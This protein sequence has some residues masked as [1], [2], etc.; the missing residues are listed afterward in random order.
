[1]AKYKYTE[2]F[3]INAPP[4]VIYPYLQSPNSLAEWFAVKVDMDSEKVFNFVWDHTDHYAKI[5]TSRLNKQIK[6]EFLGD[7]KK[8]TQDPNYIEFKLQESE[9][10]NS[11][12]LRVTDYSEMTNPRDLTDLWHGLIAQ[13]KEI[14]GG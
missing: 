11:T 13:L 8:N 3:E 10:T 14:I 5:V 6:Y 7:N 2:E 9:L 1:M 4:R 12:F